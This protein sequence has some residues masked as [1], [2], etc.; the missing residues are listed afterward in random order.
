MAPPEGLTVR[1]ARAVA[2]GALLLAAFGPA[3]VGSVEAGGVPLRERICVN[4][5]EAPV[6]AHLRGFA[7][8]C[9][10]DFGSFG[11][12][13][14]QGALTYLP[15]LL[16]R[17]DHD[18][19]ERLAA[20][21]RLWRDRA[22]AR[23]PGT[24][25]EDVADQVSLARLRARIE[26]APERFP[27][28]TLFLLG[29]E[30]GYHP[31]DDRSPE[32]IARDAVQLREML[33][34]FGRDYRLGLG[35][36]STPDNAWTRAAYAGRAGL[37]HLAAI[38]DA[39]QALEL[40]KQLFD[41][42]TIHPYPSDPAAPSVA[43][44]LGQVRAMRRLLADRGLRDRP[45]LVGEIGTPFAATPPREAE[46]FAR[47]VVSGLLH[48]RDA[49]T[50][51][52]SDGDRLVQQISWMLWQVP[53]FAVPGFTDNAALDFGR[54]A[55]VGRDGRPTPVGRAFREGVAST[56]SAPAADSHDRGRSGRDRG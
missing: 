21:P 36:I 43:D 37:E 34:G 9:W 10:K 38:L 16:W 30:P 39:A 27:D 19:A 5:L 47:D 6:A 11:G 4:A 49:E 23:R 18:T 50:G 42:F 29:I 25:V 48:L 13:L 46:R 55:L 3:R 56:G 15:T 7:I 20:L 40:E 53:G 22:L 26:A 14:D 54:S 33:S 52:P 17:E 31:A 2:F 28:G 1:G 12:P 35:G 32:A 45:L 8:G 51:L 44:S 24:R 41:A